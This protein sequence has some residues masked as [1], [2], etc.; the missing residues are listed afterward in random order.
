M[1]RT[2]TRWRRWCS[3]TRRPTTRASTTRRCSPWRIAIDRPRWHG[4][5][6]K[7]AEVGVVR[8]RQGIPIDPHA[9]ITPDPAPAYGLSYD[10][11]LGVVGD[12][13]AVPVADRADEHRSD[14]HLRPARHRPVPG[15]RCAETDHR[16]QH[17]P[18]SSKSSR[19]Q[20]ATAV[21]AGLL[22]EV[23]T[24]TWRSPD[25]MLSTA[26]D[27]RKGPTQR[28]GPDEPGDARSGRARLHQPSGQGRATDRT[29]QLAATRRTTGRD[30]H[31]RR[32][33]C[34]TTG[35]TSRST[36]RS[37]RTRPA[38]RSRTSSTRT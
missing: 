28:T 20:L 24:Y 19:S 25:V 32:A 18:A 14:Q 30:R 29:G 1:T 3:T 34:S 9:P 23:N 37:T 15:P 13:R 8:Q 33:R 2:P 22:S 35:S 31:R 27:W 6:R 16:E 36:R 7:S 11:P 12:G 26:Q 38:T 17:H 10:D 4:S 5:S 21:N